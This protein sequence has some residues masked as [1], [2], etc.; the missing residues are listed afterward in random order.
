MRAC[1]C[2]SVMPIAS[3][4]AGLR[5]GVCISSS[6]VFVRTIEGG[7][8]NEG[9]FSLEEIDASANAVCFCLRGGMLRARNVVVEW[10]CGCAFV[11]KQLYSLLFSTTLA[12]CWRAPLSLN[13]MSS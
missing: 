5:S 11:A 6:P 3:R 2:A 13:P 7:A 12:R 10:S 8:G 4:L 1:F 9:M